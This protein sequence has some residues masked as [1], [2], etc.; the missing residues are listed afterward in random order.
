MQ[1]DATELQAADYG[2][3]ALATAAPKKVRDVL[4]RLKGDGWYLDRT[5]GDDRQFKH[6]ARPGLVTVSGH[7]SDDIHPKTLGSIKNQAGWKDRA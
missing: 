5:A 6:P 3:T 7:P 1:A 2:L 4:M